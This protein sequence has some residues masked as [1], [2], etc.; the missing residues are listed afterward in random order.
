[1]LR[2]IALGALI[3]MVVLG[4]PLACTNARLSGLV[5]CQLEALKVLPDDPN[6][7]T[8]YDV[9][10]IIERVQACKRAGDAGP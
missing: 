6:M 2:D 4:L 5:R 9:V 10:D 7:A 8:I 1:M 3:G